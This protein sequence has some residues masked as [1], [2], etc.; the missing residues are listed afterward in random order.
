MDILFHCESSARKF[1]GIPEDYIPIHK[2]FDQ[3]KLFI[4]DWRHR[5]LLHHTL[6]VSLCEQMFGD[7]YTRPSDGQ[8]ISTR[9][10]AEQHVLEDLGALPDPAW[11]IREMPI[12]RWMNGMTPEQRRRTQQ[13]VL[14]D[15]R[16]ELERDYQTYLSLKSQ[17][18]AEE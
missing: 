16:K 5:A 1:G 13:L 18:E 17:F 15:D 14:E 7:F 3:S 12:R 9:L 4:A 6:G 2:F 11:Y 10:I 8:K